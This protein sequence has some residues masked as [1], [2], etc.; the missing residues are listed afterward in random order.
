MENSEYY[1]KITE[2]FAYG[3]GLSMMFYAFDNIRLGNIQWPKVI[4]D[5]LDLKLIE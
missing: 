2:N 1:N 4:S 5:G 3:L